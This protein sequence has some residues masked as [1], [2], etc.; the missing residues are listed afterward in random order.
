MQSI[1]QIQ[2]LIDGSNIKLLIYTI[3]FRIFKP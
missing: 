1:T 3:V 2:L